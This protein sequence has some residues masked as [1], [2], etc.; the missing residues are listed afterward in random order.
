[1]PENTNRVTLEDLAQ[2]VE[3]NI[4]HKEDIERLENEILTTQ[5]LVK[6]IPDLVIEK[7]TEHQGI[8]TRL[9]R[10]ERKLGIPS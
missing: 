5:A 2:M 9:E 8:L 6:K 4:A 1:M 7:L 3:R 10:V